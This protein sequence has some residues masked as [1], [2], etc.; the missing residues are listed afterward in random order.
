MYNNKVLHSIVL[1]AGRGSRMDNLTRDK[2]K[3]MVELAG[4]TLLEWQINAMMVSG[5]E[6]ILVVTGYLY[7]KI[8]DNVKTNLFIGAREKDEHFL[9]NRKTG[10]SLRESP[11]SYWGNVH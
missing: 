1:A 4:K 11:V 6:N 9:A 3:C 8:K 10:D 7:N 2:P 5:V